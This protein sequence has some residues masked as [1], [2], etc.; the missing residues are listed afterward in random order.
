MKKKI[1]KLVAE[2]QQNHTAN[3][4]HRS[5]RPCL[6]TALAAMPGVSA[7]Q[8]KQR[9]QHFLRRARIFLPVSL[10]RDTGHACESQP[11]MPPTPKAPDH[12]ALLQASCCQNNS[13]CSERAPDSSPISASVKFCDTNTKPGPRRGGGGSKT[14]NVFE[15]MFRNKQAKPLIQTNHS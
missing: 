6:Q 4:G 9:T 12:L 5:I 14:P 10:W 1:P 15:S 13:K 7:Q 2:S 11:Q 3:V 8:E